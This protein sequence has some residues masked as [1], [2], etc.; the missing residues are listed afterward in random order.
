M[1]MFILMAVAE[2]E[3]GFP[4]LVVQARSR[5]SALK[6]IG[7]TEEA[8]GRAGFSSPTLVISDKMKAKRSLPNA[9]GFCLYQAPVLR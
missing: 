9:D 5:E 3:G 7:A 4:V 2:Y 8:T 6:K 1:K